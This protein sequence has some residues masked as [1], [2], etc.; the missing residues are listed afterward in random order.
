MS[1]K[2]PNSFNKTIK[3]FKKFRDCAL[4]FIKDANVPYRLIDRIILSKVINKGTKL[5]IWISER[6]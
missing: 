1:K 5:A 3:Y 2:L 4:V 6:I